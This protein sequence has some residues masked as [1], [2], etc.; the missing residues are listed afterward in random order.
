[1][2]IIYILNSN[3]REW[4]CIAWLCWCE[5]THSLTHSLTASVCV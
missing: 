2:L 3:H 1:M 4:H 5:T